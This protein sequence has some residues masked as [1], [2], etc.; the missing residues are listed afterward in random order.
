M[1][2]AP[3]QPW[4]GRLTQRERFNRQMHWQPFD[5]T[6][7]MEF[8]YW[9]ENYTQWDIFVDNN[10]KDECDA[11]RFFAFEPPVVIDPNTWMCPGFEPKVIERRGDLVIYQNGD[12]IFN[13]VPVD[14]HSTIP[15]YIGSSVTC[16]E[17]WKRVKAEHFQRQ[18]E[19]SRI[20]WD[21][22]ESRINNNPDK[23]I[24]IWCG[25]MIGKIR[26]MLT[27]EGMVYAIADYPDMVEDMVETC[28]VLV[29]DALKELLPKY[30]FDLASGWEDIC[31]RN[32]PL[33][34]MDFFK[35]VIFPRYKRIGD[36]LHRYGIDVWY[37]DCDGDVRP[38][39]P[40]FLEA[41]INCLFPYEVN[42]CTHPVTLLKD[43]PRQLRIMG[44]ID[45]IQLIKG[46]SA[47]KEYLES[48]EPYVWDGGFIPFCDHRCPPDVKPENYL[49][50]LDLKKQM[51]GISDNHK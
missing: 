4:S 6:V 38:L 41:G 21:S 30:H 29:E 37:T 49:Y 7:N 44:G 45:K 25:S 50:Y 15:R 18:P 12:G 47:I 17:D 26:N 40:Y 51:F 31:C 19:S 5:R 39:I 36:L 8:G 2:L 33:V 34:Q 3:Y 35:S 24:C 14:G 43:Y 10:I 27:L 9:D 32:G 22:I 1:E 23:P 28:C 16:P 48:I 46:K 11:D 42:S 13:E 20:N